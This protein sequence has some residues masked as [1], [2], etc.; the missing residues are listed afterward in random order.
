MDSL[1]TLYV[2]S[3]SYGAFSWTNTRLFCKNKLMTLTSFLTFA[4]LKFLHKIKLR[5]HPTKEAKNAKV[6][7]C[8]APF[9]WSSSAHP[10]QLACSELTADSAAMAAN[11][12]IR[13]L[14]V[15]THLSA[16]NWLRPAIRR[17]R[18]RF[19]PVSRVV[20]WDTT[21]RHVHRTS[22]SSLPS[23][24]SNRATGLWIGPGQRDYS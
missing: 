14:A 15:V 7:K 23:S 9:D 10:Q 6:R 3:I 2:L 21:R 20:E 5:Q 22:A 19:E 1:W 16:V 17:S 18:T 24:P 12:S 8:D 13:R 11:S 4:H